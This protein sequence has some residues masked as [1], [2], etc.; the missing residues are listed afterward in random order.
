MQGWGWGIGNGNTR[1]GRIQIKLVRADVNKGSKKGKKRQKII[2]ASFLPFLLPSGSFKKPVHKIIRE[3]SRLLLAQ[4]A[5][6]TVRRVISTTITQINI[7]LR[8]ELAEEKCK[9]NSLLRRRS[10]TRSSSVQGLRAEWP[11]RNSP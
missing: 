9:G 8:I 7:Q 10:T 2:F 5:Y 6:A 1:C 4:T 3:G 11:R